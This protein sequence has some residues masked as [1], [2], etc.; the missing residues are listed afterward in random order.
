MKACE[1][2]GVEISRG[3]GAKLCQYCGSIE[4]L[5]RRTALGSEKR[6]R[7]KRLLEARQSVI[8]DL[9]LV[10]VRGALGGTYWE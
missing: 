3:D 2:C 7:A 5:T 4:D 1:N 9:G 10:K 8:R 6:A